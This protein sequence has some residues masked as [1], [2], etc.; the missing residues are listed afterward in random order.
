MPRQGPSA[1]ALLEHGPSDHGILAFFT[2]LPASALLSLAW[3]L[4]RR[5]GANSAAG[6]Q[7]EG[8]EPIVRESRQREGHPTLAPCAQSLCFR[9]ARPP[10]G[11]LTVHPWTGIELAHIVWAILRTSPP[12]TRRDRGDPTSAHPATAPCVALPRA[13]MPSPARQ[14]QSQSECT[15][16]RES[17]SSWL[18]TKRSTWAPYAAAT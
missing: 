18:R 11:S 15:S 16:S 6:P 8:Q 5:S 3:P 4:R 7:G 10:R 13:S 12:Q 2:R 17:A 9:C 14:S 1:I